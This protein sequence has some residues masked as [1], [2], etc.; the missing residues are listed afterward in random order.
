[1]LSSE[2]ETCIHSLFSSSLVSA[3]TPEGSDWR[4]HKLVANFFYVI[5]YRAGS[6]QRH[7]AIYLFIVAGAKMFCG[8]EVDYESEAVIICGFVSV[9]DPAI[10]PWS[11]SR[12]C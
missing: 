12:R 7:S 10:R 6:A 2:W 1:M 11:G 4:A 8:A 3:L 5:W 9:S